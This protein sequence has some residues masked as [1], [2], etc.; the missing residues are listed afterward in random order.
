MYIRVRGGC[1]IDLLTHHFVHSHHFFLHDNT[2]VRT[3]ADA[4]I[5]VVVVVACLKLAQ[6]FLLFFAPS[7]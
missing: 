2:T 4:V 7:N 6:I 1:D 3:F 5:V